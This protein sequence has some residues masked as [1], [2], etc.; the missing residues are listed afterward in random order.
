MPTGTLSKVARQ[1]QVLQNGGYPFEG[2]DAPYL[3][4]RVAGAQAQR[5]CHV[6]RCPVALA[7]DDASLCRALTGGVAIVWNQAQEAVLHLALGVGGH[8]G[9]PTLAAH[10]QMLGGQLV[11]GLAHRP[12]ADAKAPRQL[13]LT[14]DQI[15]GLPLTGLQALQNQRLDLLVQGAKCGRDCLH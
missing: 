4:H 2:Q 10:H 11:D 15:A 6:G 8:E 13:D 7:V 1:P 12:L 9:A 5:A 14:G 3:E